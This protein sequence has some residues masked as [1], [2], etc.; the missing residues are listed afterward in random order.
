MLTNFERRKH[1]VRNKL[2]KNNKSNRPKIVVKRSNKNIYAQ[3]I[4]LE[5]KVLASFSNLKLKDTAKITGIQ[6][7]EKVGEEFAKICLKDGV[8]EVIFDKGAYVYNGRVK[9][10]AEACR[11][12]GLQF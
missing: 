2:A 11:K 4:S 7:A 12:A 10:L 8:K 6:K 1:R 9:A 3:L 5:G